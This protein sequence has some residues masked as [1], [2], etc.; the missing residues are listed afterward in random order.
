MNQI[1]QYSILD[2]Y[3][4]IA[5]HDNF[6]KNAGEI[7]DSGVD[8]NSCEISSFSPL[9]FAAYRGWLNQVKFLL[10]NGASLQHQTPNG[11]NALFVSCIDRPS[12]ITFEIYWKLSRE[13]NEVVAQYLN[14]ERKK[15]E[16]YADNLERREIIEYLLNQGIN[17]D[18]LCG[19]HGLLENVSAMDAYMM[20]FFLKDLSIID[21]L[22]AAGIPIRTKRSDLYVQG[23]MQLVRKKLNYYDSIK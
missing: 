6:E 20:N 21:L 17:P 7:L 18:C 16:S 3:L 2:L 13:Q 8:I 5:K 15:Y 4:E 9:M 23:N 14:E 10:E 22:K 1:K 19:Y 11:K 12:F